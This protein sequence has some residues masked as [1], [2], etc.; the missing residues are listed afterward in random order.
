MIG[1]ASKRGVG[2]D[3]AN[4]TFA[5]ENG[6]GDFPDADAFSTTVVIYLA[7]VAPIDQR[8]ISVGSVRHMQV[9][10]DGVV[11]DLLDVIAVGNGPPAHFA[12][13]QELRIGREKAFS[14]D[15]HD[16]H[17]RSVQRVLFRHE[18]EHPLEHDSV[19]EALDQQDGLREE[20]ALVVFTVHDIE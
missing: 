2:N 7:G 20:H 11:P 12:R 3:R 16:L 4:E 14:A 17:R 1:V 10:A 19:V 18:V 8:E 6:L 15:A 9:I 13:V 5:I